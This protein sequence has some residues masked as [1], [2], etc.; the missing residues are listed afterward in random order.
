MECKGREKN[1]KKKKINLMLENKKSCI[2]LL[3]NKL[4]FYFQYKIYY[5]VL[6]VKNG[7]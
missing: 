1:K 3:N 7:K 6:C 4:C 5:I 2:I